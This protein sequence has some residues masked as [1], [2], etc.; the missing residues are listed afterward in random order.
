MWWFFTLIL[1][2]S[3]TANL[4]AFLTVE[5]MVSPINSADDLAQQTDVEYGTLRSGS[6]QEFF[7]VSLLYHLHLVK[8]SSLLVY[9]AYP[10]N[11][12]DFLSSAA[13]NLNEDNIQGEISFLIACMLR[14]CKQ[15]SHALIGRP[16]FVSIARISEFV[17]AHKSVFSIVLT[18]ARY[19]VTF[20]SILS[21]FQ[22]SRIAVYQRMWEFMSSR[23]HVFLDT[24]DEGIA[25]VRSS[26]GKYALLVESTKNDYINE[27]TPCDT[28]KVSQ[29]R[30]CSKRNLITDHFSC[31]SGRSEFGREGIR[32]RYTSRITHQVTLS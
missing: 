24:Y 18:F 17:K 14:S 6:T 31:S 21:C 26:K 4:A 11:E 23:K 32:R 1:I 12:Q 8:S 10:T 28:M 27:R 22:R 3:Y 15:K 20:R 30:K 5:R 7:R 13:S 16:T 29:P 19:R 9:G 25:R 2:S